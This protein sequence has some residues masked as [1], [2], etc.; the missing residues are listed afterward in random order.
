MILGVVNSRYKGIVRISVRGP[1]GSEV[2]V[3][4]V[5]DSGFTGSLT[6]SANAIASLGLAEQYSGGA[7][8]ADGSD[9]QFDVYAAEVAWDGDWRPVLVWA[10]GG[11]APGNAAHG[12]A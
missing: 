11:V 12:G 1:G 9:Q 8:L 7:T 3:D 4:A 2:D 5:V 6:L 10:I